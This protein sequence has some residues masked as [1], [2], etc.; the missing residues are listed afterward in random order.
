[1]PSAWF[2]AHCHLDR[3]NDVGSVAHKAVARGV[4]G[5][6]VAGVRPSRWAQQQV[7]IRA[8]ADAGGVGV[9]AAGIHPWSVGACGDEAELGTLHDLLATRPQGLVALGELGLDHRRARGEEA[10][11]VQLDVFRTQLALAREH[12]LPVVL[13]CVGADEHVLRVLKQDGL[14]AAGG[15]VH[16]FMGSAE[17]AS[18]WLRLGLHLSVGGPV[19]WRRSARRTLG[20]CSIPLNRLLVESDAPDQPVASRRSGPG[21]P[22]DV[23]EVVVALAAVL[24]KPPDEVGRQTAHNAHRLFGLDRAQ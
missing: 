15:M 11:G 12:D 23:V 10:R 9:G 4:D 19:T 20:I 18:N 13:H 1:M 5:V 2:D 22:G 7:A 21:E 3:L 6:M 17:Q 14:P 16:G 24:G 8:W